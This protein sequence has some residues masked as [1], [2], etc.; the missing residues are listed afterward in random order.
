[1]APTDS[2]QTSLVQARRL[3]ASRQYGEAKALYQSVLG[4]DATCREALEGLLTISLQLGQAEDALRHLQALVSNYPNEP[5]YCDRLAGI[6]ERRGELPAAIGHYQRL[7]AKNPGLAVSRF[8]LA[9]LLKLTGRLE[10]ALAEYSQALQLGIDRAEE[11]WCNISVI[12]SE[13]HSDDEAIAALQQALRLNPR[14][15]PAKYNLA[16]L[17]EE[18]GDWPQASDLLHDILAQDPAHY[19]ALARLANGQTI[20]DITNPIVS[21]L[22]RALRRGTI[23]AASREN[24]HFALGKVLDDCGQYPAA[25]AQYAKGNH[26][27]QH[28]AGAYDRQAWEEFVDAIIETFTHDWLLSVKPVSDAALI[29]ICGMFRSGSTLAEQV[30]AAHPEIIA[31]G[32]IDYFNGRAEQE[33]HPFPISLHAPQRA[34]LTALGQDYLNYLANTF[35]QDQ[36]ITN[37]RPDNFVYLGVVKALFPNVRI[38]HTARNPLDNC[39]SVFFQQLE[40]RQSYANDLSDI[41]HYYLQYRRLMRHWRKLFAG[42]ILDVGYERLVSDPRDEISEMLGFLALAWHEGCLDFHKTR[43]RVRTASVQQVR[44]PLYQKSS[45]RWKNYAQQLEP[46]RVQLKAA[47]QD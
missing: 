19:D 20:N 9:R 12:H 5:A 33:L 28:R 1:M 36:R 24:L 11:V 10:Q 40:S 3:Y 46:L 34:K 29:F 4:N 14:Y 8:N 26:Y 41:G 17:H 42:N 6:L 18:R 31:G 22:K 27:A 16:L 15:I 25:F 32:E 7:L 43:N 39:L 37:K 30:L 38:I 45:G 47:D 2:I 21:R 23:D 44:Q 35:S 13:R